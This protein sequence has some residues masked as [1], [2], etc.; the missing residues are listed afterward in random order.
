MTREL[1]DNA[2]IDVAR[3]A[4]RQDRDHEV[5]ELR[6]EIELLRKAADA[7]GFH[8]VLAVRDAEVKRL[9]AENQRLTALVQS[10]VI[11]SGGYVAEQLTAALE[12]LRERS[13]EEGIHH[14]VNRID[15][16]LKRKP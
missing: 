11:G 4:G 7:D 12:D 10:V 15:A 1:V 3:M 14:F 6:A 8:R 5:A 16:A 13:V 9:L 2:W